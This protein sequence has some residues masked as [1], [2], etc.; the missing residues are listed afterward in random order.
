MTKIAYIV[1]VMYNIKKYII[2]TSGVTGVIEKNEVFKNQI[3]PLKSI[4][5][6]KWDFSKVVTSG[7]NL[8]EMVNYIEIINVIKNTNFL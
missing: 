5:T 4:F 6:K 8:S 1:A 7:L 2:K 3:E